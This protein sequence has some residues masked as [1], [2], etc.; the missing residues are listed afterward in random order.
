MLSH[1]HWKNLLAACVITASSL[2]LLEQAAAETLR[3]SKD[4][5]GGFSVIQDAVD[6]AAPGDTI[7]IGAGHY[8]EFSDFQLD[9]CQTMRTYVGVPIEN[10]TIIGAHR[11]SVIIGPPDHVV[12]KETIIG[13]RLE[14]SRGFTIMNL[15]VQQGQYGMRVM[16]S[17]RIQN[18]RFRDCWIGSFTFP[19]DGA[20]F[21]ECLF[22][23]C[24]NL[25]IAAGSGS[26][27]VTV[28]RCKFV[29][30]SASVNFTWSEN[31]RVDRCSFSGLGTSR[32]VAS[33]T[34]VALT[35]SNCTI[36]GGSNYGVAV[37]NDAELVLLDSR[38]TTVGGAAVWCNGT[39]RFEARRN[40]F[41]GGWLAVLRISGQRNPV[42]ITQNEFKKGSGFA[43]KLDNYPDY[44]G[45][46]KL[47]LQNNYWNT[48]EIDS[49]RAWIW[50]G[51]DDPQQHG[52]VKVAPIL[53]FAP[54]PV[55]KISVGGLK[56][57]FKED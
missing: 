7:L 41:E 26:R 32:I 22:E 40:R 12:E 20:V 39:S 14:A 31:P 51:N 43:V 35:V 11:D 38:I 13:M 25:G 4:G 9:C 3:V 52:Y 18:V 53:P 21:E 23:R 47:S 36:E 8:T 27:N 48:C 57:S 56:S 50:D 45:E 34:G 2:V 42:T 10:L 5:S 49:V 29:D 17:A 54:V 16:D 46:W 44:L 30:N 6:A 24:R 1:S 37:V 28:D 55:E 33:G 15:T 19:D